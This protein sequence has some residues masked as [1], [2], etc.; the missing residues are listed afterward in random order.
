MNLETIKHHWHQ[1]QDS[2]IAF[3]SQFKIQAIMTSL[4]WLISSFILA[5]L[6][7]RFTAQALKNHISQHH[8][9]V[10]RRMTFY[11]ILLTGA[12]ML[13]KHLGFD[14]TTLWAGA[15]IGAAA[16]AFASQTGI[17]NVIS[18]FFLIGEKPFVIGDTLCINE[19]IGDVLSIGLLSINIRTRDNTLVRIPNEMLL[20]S[21]FQNL[22]RFPI[23]RVEIRFKIHYQEDFG[24]IKNLLLNLASEHSLCLETPSPELVCLEFSDVGLLI[25]LAVWAKQSSVF[26]LKTELMAQ[27]QDKLK[28]QKIDLPT[29]Y[30]VQD[31]SA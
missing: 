13:A 5:S 19:I 2:L 3:N 26:D 24:K 23:R 28:G 7:S 20:K 29:N 4:V 11:L 21:Q 1:I 14:L 25:Q 18:G 6:L 30:F 12:M 10:M 27:I 31:K 8:T 15:G 9:M 22:S 17:S 16:V